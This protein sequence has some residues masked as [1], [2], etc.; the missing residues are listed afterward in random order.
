VGY[1]LDDKTT[2]AMVQ[3]SFQTSYYNWSLQHSHV[4]YIN[5]AEEIVIDG[6]VLF[7]PGAD[8]TNKFT[9]F[10]A[11]Y[12][13]TRGFSIAPSLQWSD[14]RE[15]GGGRSQES[16]NAGINARAQFWQ[17]RVTL[18]LNYNLAERTDQISIGFAQQDYDSEQ[19]SLVINWAAIKA[20]GSNSGLKITLRG[21]WS[22]QASTGF[23]PLDDYQVMLGMQLYWLAGAR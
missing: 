5:E 10:S 13:S 9:T 23:Q 19:A 17:D 22:E 1:H 20:R 6:F 16:F 14:F 12:Q 18:D 7:T 3:A 8:N 11:S 15:A 4:D 2:Q 21:T